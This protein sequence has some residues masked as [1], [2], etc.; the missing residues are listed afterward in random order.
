MA[1]QN[2]PADADQSCQ[3]P[4]LMGAA[5]C[6]CNERFWG[7]DCGGCARGYA[8]ACERQLPTPQV[9]K[10]FRSALVRGGRQVDRHDQKGL[11]TLRPLRAYKTGT[12]G[13]TVENYLEVVHERSASTHSSSGST[14]GTSSTSSSIDMIRKATGEYD[15]P[16]FYFDPADRHS[17]SNLNKYLV[18]AKVDNA[19]L[20]DTLRRR[21]FDPKTSPDFYEGAYTL[22]K[23]ANLRPEALELLVER[24]GDF[25]PSYRG[26]NITAFAARTDAGVETLRAA[27]AGSPTWNGSF[28]G[29]FLNLHRS[30]QA[31]AVAPEG[32]C[33]AKELAG[34]KASR[35][36]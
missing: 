29:Y 8:G 15:L 33:D 6:L 2:L 23:C 19:T 13:W 34:S 24:V 1:A 9:R 27:P 26:F 25:F 12:G 3:W 14:T 10:S 21:M 18:L 35:R 30:H 36:A 7:D 11:D 4:V 16:Y 31:T 20:R 17:L 5:R 32:P 28:N 22:D